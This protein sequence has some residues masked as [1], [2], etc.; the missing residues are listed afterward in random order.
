[1]VELST[2]WIIVIRNP[3]DEYFT[4][5]P[6]I[7]PSAFIAPNA[8]LIGDV[9]I[10]AE[11]SIWFQAVLRADLNRIVIG[12]RS[13][14]Q[15]GTI[16]HLEHDLPTIVGNDVTCG[17]RAIL[18]ACRIED[19]VLIGMGATVLDG[20]VIGTQS[21]VGANSLVTKNTKVPP[22]SLVLGSPGRVVRALRDD[23]R[24]ALREN[25]ARYVT[26]SRRYRRAYLS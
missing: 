6:S 11:A 24:S 9:T 20:A 18:H 3:V 8:T 12:E 16:I 15:D 17:H 10:G 7:D 14:I 22:G 19:E 1:M 23:E 26:Y 13:N 5:Q 2:P 4:R 25:A 21:I